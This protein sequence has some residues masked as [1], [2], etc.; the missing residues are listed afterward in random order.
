MGLQQ[1]RY[2]VPHVIASTDQTRTYT[3]HS[4]EEIPNVL[5]QNKEHTD[6]V[7]TTGTMDSYTSNHVLGCILI[8]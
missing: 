6:T 2:N 4:M 3:P 5:Y 8:H 7:T 1:S